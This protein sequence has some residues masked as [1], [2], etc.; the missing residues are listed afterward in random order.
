[1]KL[2]NLK[3]SHFLTIQRGCKKGVI[4]EQEGYVWV[5]DENRFIPIQYPSKNI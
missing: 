4:D 3:M 1:M 5:V 2:P